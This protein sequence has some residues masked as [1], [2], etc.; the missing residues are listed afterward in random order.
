MPGDTGLNASHSPDHVQSLGPV[1]HTHPDMDRSGSSRLG[2]LIAVEGIDG[3]G[4]TTQVRLLAEAL[5]RLGALV[6]TSKEPTDGPWGRKIRESAATGRL[7]L[8]EELDA[9]VND[10]IDHVRS[11][12]R[13]ALDDGKVVILDR[14]FYSTIAYQGSRGRD[15]KELKASMEQIAPVPD[16]VFLLEVAP[17]EGIRRISE[18]RKER[19]N[20]FEKIET[21]TRV[22]EAFHAIPEPRI[23]QIDGS[24]PVEDVHAAIIAELARRATGPMRRLQGVE[25]VRE[26]A[27]R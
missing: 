5:R 26:S 27:A 19:P 24:R 18:S 3:A 10:R 17:E 7:S 14:Y 1:C 13:P 2:L 16:I 12:I 4:K 6:I 22:R 9:F 21:L 25:P 23:V 8:E 20:E 15:I 11:L